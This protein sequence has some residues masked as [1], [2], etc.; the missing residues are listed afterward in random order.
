MSVGTLGVIPSEFWYIWFNM[1]HFTFG[2][3]LVTLSVLVVFCWYT[4][5]VFGTLE[6]FLV[7]LDTIGT[8]ITFGTRVAFW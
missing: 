5:Q 8:V 3:P 2:I 4:K 6:S 1:A 7:I